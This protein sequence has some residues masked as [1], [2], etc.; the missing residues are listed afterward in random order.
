MTNPL[1]ADNLRADPRIEEAKKLLQD[2]VAEHSKT[3]VSVRP[4]NPELTVEY[5]KLLAEF[6]SIR[7]NNIF[8]PYLG[9]GIGNGPFVELADGSVKLDMIT[10]IGV[11][12]YGHSH[13]LLINAGVDAAISDTVMPVSYTHLTLP[14][15]YS[16]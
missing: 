6:G 4:P 7:G 3:L 10:G 5:E 13:P 11:H 15:I 9:S 8:F 1:H 12:G 14:T 16:V 2:A